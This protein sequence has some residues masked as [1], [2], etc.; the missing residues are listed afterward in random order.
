M[1]PIARLAAAQSR[2]A[3]H[4]LAREGGLSIGSLE[5]SFAALERSLRDRRAVDAISLGRYQVRD[6]IGSGAMG[7]VFSGYDPKLERPVALKIVRASGSEAKDRQQI[8][9]LLKEAVTVARFSHPHIVAVHDVQDAAGGAFVAMELIEGCSLESLVDGRGSLPPD[10]VAPLGAAVAS[11]LAAAHQRGLV[12]RDVKPPNVLLGRDGAIKVTDFGIAALVSAGANQ[13]DLIFGTPGSCRRKRSRRVDRRGDL[14]ALG[15]TRYFAL[16]GELPFEGESLQDIL[17]ATVQA[18]TAAAAQR[19]ETFAGARSHRPR[20][21]RA[22][23]G[24]AP[25]QRR[26]SR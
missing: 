4:S 12:H 22:R 25:S 23:P 11:A 8:Q 10:L 1:R 6:V 21:A 24:K 14:F 15:A 9:R 26:S 7:T 13:V 19:V 17:R 3:G 16:T 2:L 5:E 20:S 18:A